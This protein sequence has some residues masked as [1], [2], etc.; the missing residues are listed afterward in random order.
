MNIDRN[1]IIEIIRHGKDDIDKAEDII[2]SNEEIVMKMASL[3]R[4]GDRQRQTQE[5]VADTIL[6][7]LENPNM[8][9]N[10]I[11]MR[12]VTDA[13]MKRKC[14]K[15]VLT[16]TQFNVLSKNDDDIILYEDIYNSYSRLCGLCTRSTLVGREKYFL[17]NGKELALSLFNMTNGRI[18]KNMRDALT[19]M[20]CMDQQMCI[21][22]PGIK[23][24]LNR[25]FLN[26]MSHA[27]AHLANSTID[28]TVNIDH[29]VTSIPG[30][31]RRDIKANVLST[32]G[33]KLELLNIEQLTKVSEYYRL[34]HVFR[35]VRAPDRSKVGICG[36]RLD[37]DHERQKNISLYVRFH[38][39]AILN[40]KK[41]SIDEN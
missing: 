20:F 39:I 38:T 11:S 7:L 36:E 9:V 14:H 12:V 2:L 4:D 31:N 18:S 17:E 21:N 13:Y 16:P 33:S 6:Q 29:I 40:R 8:E 1:R 3:I 22:Q 10:E 23:S 35:T 26:W 25:S 37:D 32:L 15:R 5:E 19:L 41:E 30:N 34:D 28:S 27:A 24:N